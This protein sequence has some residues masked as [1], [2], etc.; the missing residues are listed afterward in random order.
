M[1]IPSIEKAV[2]VMR[3]NKVNMGKHTD[4]G[5]TRK[6]GRMLKDKNISMICKGTGRK[7]RN[8]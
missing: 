1:N 3:I 7:S 5:E 4:M 2:A 6:K 8:K